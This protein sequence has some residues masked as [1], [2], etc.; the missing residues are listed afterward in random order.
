[1]G[2]LIIDSVDENTEI[3]GLLR[4]IRSDRVVVMGANAS[5]RGSLLEST[6]DDGDGPFES[7]DAV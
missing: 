7:L 5:V 3:F 6:A 1:M 2:L 4:E